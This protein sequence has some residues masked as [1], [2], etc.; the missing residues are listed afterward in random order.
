MIQ[1]IEAINRW[2]GQVGNR[3]LTKRRIVLFIIILVASFAAYLVGTV[4]FFVNLGILMMI[5]VSVALLA[6]YFITPIL[7]AWSQPFSS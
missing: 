4:N 6:D 1:N 3:I 7:I 5:G 2:F